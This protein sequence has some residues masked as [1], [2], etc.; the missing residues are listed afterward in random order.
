MVLS[1]WVDMLPCKAHLVGR[2]SKCGFVHAGWKG[3]KGT[4]YLA[5]YLRNIEIGGRGLNVV[6]LLSVG[7]MRHRHVMDGCH[8]L[9]VAPERLLVAT[10]LQQ[11]YIF[12]RHDLRLHHPKWCRITRFTE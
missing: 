3:E 2:S 5:Q 12:E 10:P 8:A 4:T 6:L 11:K 1:W 9:H 7:T